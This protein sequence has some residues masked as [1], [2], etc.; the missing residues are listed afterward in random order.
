MRAGWLGTLLAVLLIPGAAASAAA[1]PPARTSCTACH[2]DTE[3]FD[4]ETARIVAAFRGD[5]HASVG[6]SCHDCHGG[7]PDPDLADDPS[8]MDPDFARNPYR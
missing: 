1:A 6:L 2:A 5:V 3:M 4:E 8:A 7:N